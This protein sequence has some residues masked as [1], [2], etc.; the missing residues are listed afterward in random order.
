[1]IELIVLLTV[2]TYGTNF[3]LYLILKNKKSMSI[4][5]KDS[6]VIGIN[7]FVFVLDG[8]FAF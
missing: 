6:I 7:T 1:M 2:F 4:A 5:D 8:I 3:V